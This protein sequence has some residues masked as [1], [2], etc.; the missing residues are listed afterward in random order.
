MSLRRRQQQVRAV[1]TLM[2]AAVVVGAAVAAAE[3]VEAEGA[4]VVAGPKVGP[5]AA[6]LA[7][8]RRGS[9][10]SRRVVLEVA[11]VSEGELRQDVQHVTA[12]IARGAG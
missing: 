6:R 3:G 11:G 1:P 2:V 7:G 10:G 5:A 9:S 8:P 4:V 12:A